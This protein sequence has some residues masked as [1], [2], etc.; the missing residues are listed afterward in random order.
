MLRTSPL[1]ALS[2]AVPPV[3]RQAFGYAGKRYSPR[4]LPVAGLRSR[5]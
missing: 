1:A 4:P 3:M 2:E 5:R